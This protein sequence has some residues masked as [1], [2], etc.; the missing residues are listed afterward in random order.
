MGAFDFR[1]KHIKP[2]YQINGQYLWEDQDVTESV[3]KNGKVVCGVI[4]IYSD[5]EHRQFGFITPETLEAIET[6]RTTWI[7]QIGKEPKPDQPFFYLQP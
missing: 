2:V 1:W 5:A 7:Q 3:T 6:Y 4:A